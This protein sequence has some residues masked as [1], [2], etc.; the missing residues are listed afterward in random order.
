MNSEVYQKIAQV[1]E[2]ILKRPETISLIWD[3][4]DKSDGKVRCAKV[5]KVDVC[6][7][8]RYVLE[9]HEQS[10]L[11]SHIGF[12]TS[13]ITDSF[14]CDNVLSDIQTLVSTVDRYPGICEH[15]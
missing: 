5:I 3:L 10:K 8:I 2:D 6:D 1:W 11:L 15:L 7:R 9:Y 14:E 13:T 4:P 12:N